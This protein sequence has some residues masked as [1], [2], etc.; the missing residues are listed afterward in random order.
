MNTE[1]KSTR[2]QF[3]DAAGVVSTDWLG[4]VPGSRFCGVVKKHSSDRYTYRNFKV[5]CRNSKWLIL[6]ACGDSHPADSLADSTRQ[7]DAWYKEGSVEW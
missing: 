6:S 5:I 3:Q 4:D 7:I 2:G 1:T